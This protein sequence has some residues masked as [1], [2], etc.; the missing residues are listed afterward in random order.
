MKKL[1]IGTSL[2]FVASFAVGVYLGCTNNENLK[3]VINAYNETVKGGKEDE[4]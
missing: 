3:K 4:K 1:I 2:M